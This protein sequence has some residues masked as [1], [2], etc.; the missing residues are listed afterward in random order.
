MGG[1]SPRG[2]CQVGWAE[3]TLWHLRRNVH[4]MV[5]CE[6]GM[7]GGRSEVRAAIHSMILKCVAETVDAAVEAYPQGSEADAR[8]RVQAAMC[9][10]MSNS[11]C[12]S[13]PPRLPRSKTTIYPVGGPPS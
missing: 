10:R 4:R 7:L 6:W 8:E 1:L 5:A 11:I 13:L 3:M 9:T 12:T 2:Q